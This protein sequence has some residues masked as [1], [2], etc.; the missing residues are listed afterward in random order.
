MESGPSQVDDEPVGA[1]A[2]LIDW[3]GRN[4]KYEQEEFAPM[5]MVIAKVII[6]GRVGTSMVRTVK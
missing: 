6:T 2:H 5:A 4:T 3:S 1:A